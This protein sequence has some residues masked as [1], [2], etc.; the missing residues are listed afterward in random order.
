MEKVENIDATNLTASLSKIENANVTNLTANLAN[1][2]TLTA[3]LA[4]L[5]KIIMPSP[6]TTPSVS[7]SIGVGVPQ[8]LEALHVGGNILATGNITANGNIVAG[9]TKS[10]VF[11]GRKYYAPE[12]EGKALYFSF[13]SARARVC[14]KAIELASKLLGLEVQ[15]KAQKR[16]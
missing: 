3:N 8:P 11:E 9:G 1:L 12:I 6:S 2:S 14:F 7:P 10:S 5:T 13:K 16:N 15:D 4:N